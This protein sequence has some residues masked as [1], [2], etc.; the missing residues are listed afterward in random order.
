MENV[1]HKPNPPP[2]WELT[3]ILNDGGSPKYLRRA[4]L[5]ICSY[6]A[7][8]QIHH[9]RVKKGCHLFRL[10]CVGDPVDRSILQTIA[11]ETWPHLNVDVGGNNN[12]TC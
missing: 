9:T 11:N 3:I 6:L 7:P 10:Q 5:I 12:V 4:Y 8:A 2:T 1:L